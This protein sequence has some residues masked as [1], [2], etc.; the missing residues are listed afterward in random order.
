MLFRVFRGEK[1]G[2]DDNDDDNDCEMKRLSMKTVKRFLATVPAALSLAFAAAASAAANPNPAPAGGEIAGVFGIGGCNFRTREHNYETWIPQMAAIGINTVRG[3]G[4]TG[5]TG[6]A[7]RNY[8]NV[9]WQAEYLARHGIS[10]GG[11]FYNYRQGKGKY[12]LPMDDLPGWAADVTR[13]TAHFKGKIKYWEIWNEPPNGTA[14]GQ[15]AADYARFAIATYDAAKKGDPDCLVGIA[16]KSAAINYIDQALA[17]GAAG[18]F[19]YITLHPYE[20]AGC[21][22][23][24]PGTEPVYLQIVPTVRKMLAARDPAKVNC[25]VIFTELG[26]AAGGQYNKGGP[27]TQAYAVVKYYTLAI[28]QGVACLQWFEGMDGDSGPMGLMDARGK[29]RPAYTAMA[30]MIKH[31][32]QKPQYLGWVLL[33]GKHYGFV[34]QGAKGTVL[35]A[36]AA[37][38]EADR[39]DF[40]QPVK[41]VDPLTGNVSEAKTCEL[42][43]A[44]ILVDGVPEALLRTARANRNQPI[45]WG[46]DYSNA[47]SVSITFGEKNVEKG[48]HTQSAAS[49][50]AA[51][52]GYGGGARVGNVPGGNIFLVDPNFLSYDATPIEISI[53]CHRGPDNKPAKIGIEYE[54]TSGYKKL[55]A[56]EIP[57]SAEWSTAKWKITDAQF[58][59]MWAYN[60][61]ISPGKYYIQSVTVTRL[62]RK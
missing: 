5:W 24:H 54:S 18:H 25:P 45:P 22:M 15:T 48:L 31:F 41:I 21:I 40:G 16:A 17:A 4:G 27:D 9:D 6:E 58:V 61:S 32:S 1:A 36:W 33:N 2:N 11:G 13:L 55:P 59:S 29:P 51:V 12:G 42:T 50:A 62:D 28:V 3:L 49:V 53:V 47:K 20:T 37:G 8:A 30:Q 26:Y 46:G 57:E 52:V 38:K 19:D 10:F 43:L 44:P 39:V 56:Y 14:P 23:D 60:F 35:A 7:E 34:F